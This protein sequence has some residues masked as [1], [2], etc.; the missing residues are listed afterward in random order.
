MNQ[1]MFPDEGMARIA[2]LLLALFAEREP[3]FT[4]ERAARAFTESK[5]RHIG[6]P[7]GWPD[8]KIDYT[9]S[10]SRETASARSRARPTSR[11][12]HYTATSHRSPEQA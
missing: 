11:R 2:F 10:A 8:D 3:T 7:P 5:G 12:D 6:R 1:L 4:A 9:R